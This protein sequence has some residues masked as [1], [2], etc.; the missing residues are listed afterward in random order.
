[1]SARHLQEVPRLADK[2]PAEGKPT[3][4]LNVNL[5]LSMYEDIEKQ[6]RK[7]GWTLTDYTRLA[8][9]LLLA[10][11]DALDQG[12]RLTVTTKKGQVVKEILLPA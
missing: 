6:A 7:H 3:K 5:P 8:F 1:M 10:G 4:R 2:Q 11:Y 9:G 12:N